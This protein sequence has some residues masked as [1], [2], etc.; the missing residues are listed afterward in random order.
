MSL[1]LKTIIG[2][3]LI[4]GVL[5]IILITTVLSYMRQ[6]NEQSLEQY[7]KTTTNLFA[8]TTKDAVLS[9]D[10]A[11]LE[12]FIEE[13]LKNEGVGYTRIYDN[14]DNILAEGGDSSLLAKTFIEDKQYRD[15]TDTVYDSQALISVDNTHYGRIEMGISTQ[16]IEA[17]I[18]ETRRLAAIIAIAE[19]A[20]VALF[21][22]FLGTYLTSQLKVLHRASRKIAQ[23]DLS[24]KI[25]IKT[26][27]EV[28][29]VA[30]SFNK[31]VT[32]LQKAEADSNNHQ[33]E[34][35]ALNQSLEDR[36]KRRT[37]KII[38]Q[39]DSLQS[40]F[41]KLKLT[42]QQL[43][44]SEKMASIGQLAAG[45]AHEINNPIAFVKSNLNSLAGYI[46]SYRQLI[47]QQQQLI[48]LVDNHQQ[49]ESKEL[50]AAI[51][52]DYEEA[53]IEFVNDDIETLIKESIDGTQ[54]IQDIVGGLKTYAYRSDD[55][56][57]AHSINDCL[58]TTLKMLA[59]ELKYKCEVITHFGELPP[60]TGNASKL[61]QVYTNLLINANHAIAKQG[62][63]TV[64]TAYSDQRITISIA[65]TGAGIDPQNL[66]KLFDPFFTTKDVGE[67]TGLGLAI[68]LGIINDHKGSIDVAST[69]GEGTVFTLSLPV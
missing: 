8:T 18:K 52:H 38:E 39:K 22:F 47:A 53:D 41:D 16:A 48:T 61:A 35:L 19:M 45:V 24:H 43:L 26:H 50:I 30:H 23:G 60:Y 1:R 32:S 62:T 10:L 7:V 25:D 34:L 49:Q 17:A 58:R 3:G 59:N 64:T 42:Q 44:Q 67:G 6:T 13:I 11:S 57:E 51:K 40:A 33:Q 20:L 29:E 46:D 27:D 21:S 66:A 15:V 68:S 69:P 36:I 12:T 28:G 4:E 31:M 54:R 2:I 14:N 65:D 5:L 37:A 9:F 55:S 63:I 56:M